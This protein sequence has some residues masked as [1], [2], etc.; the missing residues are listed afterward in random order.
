MVAARPAGLN[1]ALAEDLERH[2]YKAF[3][4]SSPCE[5]TS[6]DPRAVA[7]WLSTNV[8]YAVEVPAIPGAKLLGARR[9]KLRGV[10]TAS[11]QYRED[12]QALTLFVTRTGTP[13][14]RDAARFASNSPRCT[15]GSLGESI[16]AVQ[17]PSG[18]RIAVAELD[19]ASLLAA[20]AR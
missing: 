12:G 8:G 11:L 19:D 5:F 1:S 20:L 2:H 3:G 6:S 18:A 15:H 7:A 14:A 10:L 16:C 13:V 17:G 9:C 4:Q